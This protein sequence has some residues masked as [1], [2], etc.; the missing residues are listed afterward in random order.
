LR[1]RERRRVEVRKQRR[2]KERKERR[3]KRKKGKER[4]K[5]EGGDDQPWQTGPGRRF[6]RLEVVGSQGPA[7]MRAGQTQDKERCKYG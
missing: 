6:Q 7:A 3:K 4:K 1:E 2:E 5:G